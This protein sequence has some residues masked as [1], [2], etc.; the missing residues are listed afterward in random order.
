[1]IG[2]SPIDGSS[3]NSSFGLLMIARAIASICCSPPD[4]VPASCV[5]RS[6]SRGKKPNIRSMSCL[7]PSL[8]L[9]RYAPICMF[10]SI[11]MRAKMPRPSGTIARPRR[12]SSCAGSPLI[13]WPMYSMSPA[14]YGF[15]PVI[16]FIVVVLPAPFAPISVTSSPCATSMS[17]PL[18]A[19][20]P[21]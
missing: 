18:T 7:M 2:D 8:S 13:D 16:A 14:E 1:M 3:S 6:F 5:A 11:D 4:S 15:R 12:S 20:M 17:T 9:R 10:S 19:W 21:P